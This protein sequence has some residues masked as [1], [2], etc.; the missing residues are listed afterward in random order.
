MNWWKQTTNKLADLALYMGQDI[1][2]A[3]HLTDTDVTAL[4]ESSSFQNWKKSQ[5]NQSKGL[6]T[7][8]SCINSVTKS[9]GN[10]ANV[11]AKRR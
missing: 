2:S 3:M 1:R 8:I 10:L 7:I 9:V 11:L 5:E 6:N 4:F